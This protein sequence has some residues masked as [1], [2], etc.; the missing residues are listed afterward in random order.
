MKHRSKKAILYIW[1]S[2]YGGTSTHWDVYPEAAFGQCIGFFAF[3]R[4]GSGWSPF[5]LKML[6]VEWAE[7]ALKAAMKKFPDMDVE[8]RFCSPKLG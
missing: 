5:G 2:A 8:A 3:G 6:E 1:E 4:F 7:A